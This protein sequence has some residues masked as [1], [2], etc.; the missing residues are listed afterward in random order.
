MA[1][2]FRSRNNNIRAFWLR[3]GARHWRSDS[4]FEIS[5]HHFSV[6]GNHDGGSLSARC[7]CRKNQ[8][9]GYSLGLCAGTGNGI[10]AWG[11]AGVLVFGSPALAECE[12]FGLFDIPEAEFGKKIISGRH[13]TEYFPA[14]SRIRGW[15]SG[16]NI[17][18]VRMC[19]KGTVSS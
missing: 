17:L 6:T 13:L 12:S 5:S 3:F 4:E 7:D 15:F 9:K 11:L 14:L 8:E 1:G 16:W 2:W 10:H 19:G 18:A